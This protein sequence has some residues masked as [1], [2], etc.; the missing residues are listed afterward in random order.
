MVS[1]GAMW[2]GAC[3]GL[4]LVSQHRGVWFDAS[5]ASS[6]PQRRLVRKLPTKL[7]PAGYA[8]GLMTKVIFLRDF[9]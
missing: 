6:L 3:S 4:Q 5:R 9:S 7:P 1:N 8:S 2:E